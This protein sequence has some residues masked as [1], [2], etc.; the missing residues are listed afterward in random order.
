MPLYNFKEIVIVPSSDDLADIIL[1]R[2]QRQTPSLIHPRHK[3]G[4]VRSFY[5]RKVKYTQQNLRDKI[6]EILEQ[7]PRVDDIHP[8]YADLLNVLYDRDHYKLALGQLSTARQ[9]VDKIGQDYIKLLK[10]GDSIYRCKQLKRAALGRMVSLIKKQKAS[11]AYLEQVRQH[12][13]RL[14]SIDP[15][16]RS[17]LV[18][19]YPNVGKS[20]FINKISRAEVEVQPYAFTTKALYVGHMDYKYLRWQVIDTPGVLDRPLEDRNTIEM[21]S[22]TALAHLKACVLY[23][24]DISEQCGYTIE[25]QSALFHSIKPLFANKPII[26]VCSKCDVRKAEELSA[27]DVGRIEHMAKEAVRISGADP[28]TNPETMVM[29]MS[30][31]KEEGIMNVKQV[32]CERLLANR[33]GT[34]VQ[35]KKITDVVNRVHV[36]VPKP[37]DDI[38]RPPVI[39]PG[40]EEAR[41]KRDAGLHVIED[42]EK[43]NQEKFGGAGVYSANLRKTYLLENPDWKEDIIPEFMDG[44]NVFDFIDPEIDAKLAELEREEE[45]LLA[46]AQLEGIDMDEELTEEQQQTLNEIEERK[47][48]IIYK[49][50]QKKQLAGNKS[51]VPRKHNTQGEFTADKMKA[52]L[53]RLGM[54][55][56]RAIAEARGR[57]ET[58][59]KLIKRARS[60]GADNDTEMMDALEPEQKKRVH[61]TKSRSMSRGRSFSLME[62][63][64]K[65][66]LKDGVQRA[67]AIK[68]SDRMQKKWQKKAR[69]G[70]ADRIIPN[71][72]PKHLFTGKGGIGKRDWR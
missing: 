30:A 42:D 1:S 67:R 41:Q 2:T 72:M 28:E 57:S 52:E 63:R 9:I 21:Q 19:G 71:L 51:V 40:V 11:L 27:E 38:Q 49:H 23:L 61:S 26:I 44:A 60:E 45:E 66:G 64:L 32:A 53:E 34:K 33:V 14:P 36:A 70:E 12:M 48:L 37:R 18:C 58:R 56:S 59:K 8:F 46:E 16:T 62:P 69:K 20:S 10:Y 4:S 7:F 24:L 22:I 39:P 43:I 17:L 55:P 68:L 3:I 31:L 50:R 47:S 29:T 35:G 65:D 6:S 54:D 13:S 15:T 25:Q 5:M